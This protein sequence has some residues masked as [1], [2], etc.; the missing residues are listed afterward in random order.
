MRGRIPVWDGEREVAAFAWRGTE[1]SG[2]G[3]WRFS[4]EGAKTK[5]KT[6]VEKRKGLRR[7][8]F[9]DGTVGGGAIRGWTGF[10]GW[11][12]ALALCLPAVGY[13][14]RDETVEWP[15]G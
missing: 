10:V 1:R 5:I 7:V 2:K 14:I 9:D 8:I 11:Y 13:E 6:A 12:Q 4:D 15:I 3:W